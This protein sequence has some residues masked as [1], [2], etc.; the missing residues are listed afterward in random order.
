RVAKP[1][2]LSNMTGTTSWY[3]MPEPLR[4]RVAAN[5]AKVKASFGYR[6]AAYEYR[7]VAEGLVDFSLHY[8]LMPWDHAAG[9]L[10]HAEA[11][12]YTA[13]LDGNPYLPTIFEGGVISA[14]NR[15]CWQMLHDALLG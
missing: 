14:S 6:C 1:T 9:V 12:G 5:L 3:I 4:S 7:I 11:G 2:Q 15:E 10:I 13:L 8:K